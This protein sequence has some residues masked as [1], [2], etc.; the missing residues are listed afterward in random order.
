MENI[1]N[2]VIKMI[3]GIS[4]LIILFIFSIVGITCHI[5]FFQL[6]EYGS[7]LSEVL[8]ILGFVGVGVTIGFSICLTACYLICKD[9]I[10]I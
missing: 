3:I 6:K 9:F 1:R 10:I 8:M 4:L 5:I 7:L 2:S